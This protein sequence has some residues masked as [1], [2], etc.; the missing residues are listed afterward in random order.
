ML[1]GVRRVFF[2]AVVGGGVTC[3]EPLKRRLRGV[4]LF[5]LRRL[6]VMRIRWGM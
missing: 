4:R 5:G 3:V 2:L 1:L 6:L